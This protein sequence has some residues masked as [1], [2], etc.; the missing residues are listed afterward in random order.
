MYI[1]TILGKLMD[2][3]I[4]TDCNPQNA[5]SDGDKVCYGIADKRIIAHLADLCDAQTSGEFAEIWLNDKEIIGIAFYKEGARTMYDVSDNVM[6]VVSD[7]CMDDIY[8]R[9]CSNLYHWAR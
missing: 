5:R 3:V 1:F 7:A 2:E 6:Q 9:I 8:T 4:L